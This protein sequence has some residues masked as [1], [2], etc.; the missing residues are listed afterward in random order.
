[1]QPE[2]VLF[3][4]DLL[5]FDK[6]S[7]QEQEERQ[8]R[9]VNC[10][11]E[12]AHCVQSIDG[13]LGPMLDEV[14]LGNLS[15]GEF[16]G[17]MALL[18]LKAG[19]KHRRTATSMTNA[20]LYSLSKQKVELVAAR[21]PGLKHQLT[22]H[23]EDFEKSTAVRFARSGLSS[24]V[25]DSKMKG[26]GAEQAG[27]G[28]SASD[29]I[30]MIQEHLQQQD[31]KM[32]A[33]DVKLDQQDH[34]MHEIQVQMR[35]MLRLLQ[36]KPPDKAVTVGTTP[37]PKKKEHKVRP[38]SDLRPSRSP[39]ATSPQSPRKPTA[40]DK[41]KLEREKERAEI[42][43]RRKLEREQAAAKRESDKQARVAAAADKKNP[44]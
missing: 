44:L 37:G 26:T 34:A 43:E 29:P 6:G 13:Y 18:P 30:S 7:L 33:L 10:V 38:L 25:R 28:S 5:D 9:V 19:W 31:V 20:L 23:A 40:S 36:G 4:D 22:D 39:R 8:Q 27:S 15:A 11:L 1:M 21:F 41:R 24:A 42:A 32:T 14:H 35:Q 16:F 3:E 17:E 12:L 2:S